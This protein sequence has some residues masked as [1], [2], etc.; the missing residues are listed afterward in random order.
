[1]KVVVT[2]ADQESFQRYIDEVN[3]YEEGAY[4][5]V[6]IKEGILYLKTFHVE[7]IEFVDC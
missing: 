5:K 3:I 4:T 2:M 1:M 6:P 7:T